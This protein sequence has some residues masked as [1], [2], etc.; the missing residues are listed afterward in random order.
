M[1]SALRFAASVFVII[2][3]GA[4][5][6]SAQTTGPD[7]AV[8]ANGAVTQPLALTPAQRTAIYNEV[9]QQRVR[10][11]SRRIAVSI[12]AP[13]PPWVRLSD[14]PGQAA[15]DDG[16]TGVLKYAM[17]GDDVVVVDPVSMRVV[18]VIRR[19]ALP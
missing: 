2:L 15:I 12:G 3:F 8:E 6:A 16:G 1:T 11:S 17:V 5:T 9:M 10:S 7:E 14:L 19:G 13:V 18:D 4:G